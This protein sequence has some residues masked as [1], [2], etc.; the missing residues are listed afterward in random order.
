MRSGSSGGKAGWGSF[1]GMMRRLTL[2]MVRGANKQFLFVR[3]SF[4]LF[5]ITHGL[6]KVTTLW[7]SGVWVFENAKVYVDLRLTGV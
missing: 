6:S 3:N 2:P 1:L 5:A 7:A 4:L